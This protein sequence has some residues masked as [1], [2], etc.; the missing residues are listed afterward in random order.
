MGVINKFK[1]LIGLEEFEDEFEEE[2]EEYP[3]PER[4]YYERRKP[5]QNMAPSGYGG[6]FQG[7]GHIASQ[8]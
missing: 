1:G 4:P 7:E 5:D 2:Y 8:V 6:T 3:E